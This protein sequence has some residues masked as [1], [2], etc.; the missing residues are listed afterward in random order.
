MLFPD[1]DMR[2]WEICD[3]SVVLAN[4]D[5]FYSKQQ[6]DELLDSVSG[7]SP[8]EVQTMINRSLHSK[9]DK[10]YV[11]EQDSSLS[12]DIRAINAQLTQIYKKS[13]V[14]NLL[15][16]KQNVLIAGSGI[17]ISGDVISSTGGGG[18]VTS[19][20]VQ[21]MI[22]HSISGKVDTSTFN[23][24]S[25]STNVA[26]NNKQDTLIAG[27]NITIVNNVISSTASGDVT[28]AQV[29]TMIATSISGKADTT[30]VT[31]D[32]A[33]ATADMATQT[34]VQNQGYLTEHQSL[35]AYSTTDEMNQAISSATDDM[36][37]ETWVGNQ[38]Y[39]T[40]V[41][42]S[43][44]ATLQDIPTSNSALTN[45]AGYITSAALNGYAT[46]QWVQNQGYLTEH[47]SLSAYS[48]T[49][50]VNNA[51]DAA[52]SGK[53]DSTA[54]TQDIAAAT[55]DMATETWVQNQG[56][57]TEHQSLSA[58]STTQEM[59][60]AITAA[61]DDMA[62]ETWVNQQGFLTEHQSLSA[63]STTA[64]M[65]EAISASTSG[66][67]DTTA[68]TQDIATATADMATKTW[69][70]EQGY[71]TEHQS[72]SAYSTTVEMDNAIDSAV[73]GKADSTAVT[74]DIAAATD[75]MATRTWVGEQG[76]LT[77]H[78][79]L[80]AYS[81]TVEMN[82]A[83]DSAVSGKQD[84]LIS[85]TNIKTINNVSILG[86]GNVDI[87]GSGNPT[88]EVTQA[89]YDALVSAGTVSAD[90]FYIITDAT[91]GDLSNY[92]TKSET[93]GATQIST[94]LNAKADTAT[95]YTKT[96][97]DTALGG[98]QATLVSGTNIKTIN[99]ES[100][101]GSGNITIQGGG[102]GGKAISAGT[103]ISV[104]T[105][106]TAD[107]IN[108][109][110][111]ISA[112]TGTNSLA[113]GYADASLQQYIPKAS[114]EF[115]LAGGVGCSALT[116]S[117]VALGYLNKAAGG[118]SAYGNFAQGYG[119][120]AS[121][122]RCHSEGLGTSSTADASHSEGNNTTASGNYSHSE[123]E[124]VKATNVAEHSQGRY[125]VSNKANNT[126]GDSGNTL[127][128]VGNGTADNARHN[129]FE[130]RQNGDIY[131]SDGTNDVKL[132]D[133]ITATAANTTALG[134]LKLVKLTQQEYDA[135][136]SKDSNT[137]YVIV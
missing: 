70:G 119:T 22:D 133:T 51:I 79:S 49:V 13:D 46:E 63:Y 81:T 129:A 106:E 120:T 11:D 85:G 95:T 35:S 61:T 135:L 68:V 9:A 115:S 40:G 16:R 33:T 30:A 7:M 84:T 15:D 38:G 36:A 65:N 55:D 104:T 72:L 94:A 118:I 6:T 3:S 47:Q 125:N 112:G 77:E 28:S 20:Q 59:N 107:T 99:N 126:W 108:C 137:L 4:A 80:S 109:T 48:T 91:A 96:E 114:G 67:A 26:I 24:Y 31:Q 66:K 18:D 75:D 37:T 42:L 83:I 134:G 60:D 88:V 45:D 128:S 131:C 32:I 17:T 92:Y 124:E 103:N 2:A 78:Q 73:S 105:G 90:T 113:F 74:Q 100:I 87:Q 5:N 122:N 82:N 97:V 71:L 41:D 123:G 62:T 43:N 54:V 102:G 130:I 12:N 8:D 34:W 89:E 86:S 110:L 132:Q 21:S 111:P 93:S 29:E 53:A 64:E 101:L 1:C 39:I 19:G 121:G 136:I 56:Y 69:V 58:Y 98:K 23:T 27:D 127:F 52:V 50:E 76:Y 25:A 117:S 116:S 10:T 14:N 44:Y 57:L